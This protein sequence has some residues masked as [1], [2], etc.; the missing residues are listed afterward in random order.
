[1]IGPTFAD[2]L[3]AAGLTDLMGWGADGTFEF[4]DDYPEAERRIFLAVLEAHDGELST[5][6]HETAEAIRAEAS[7]RIATLFAQ[8]PGSLD[9]VFAE[10]N[11]L[12]GAVG[13]IE[14]GGSALPEERVD[15]DGLKETW[16]R[17]QA[18]RE[19]AR[20]GKAEVMAAQTAAEAR[21]VE[22]VWPS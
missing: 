9:L 16:A 19:A 8:P 7:A 12:A 1:M 21:G 15:L 13:I 17:I 20:T 22:P 10:L 6:R 18:I 5:A 3:R 2:E 14:K 4:R 11:A